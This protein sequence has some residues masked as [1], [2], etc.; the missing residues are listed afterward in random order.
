MLHLKNYSY[1]RGIQRIEIN[2]MKTTK[3]IIFTAIAVLA[4]LN[5]CQT[6]RRIS[7]EYYPVRQGTKQQIYVER[8]MRMLQS[9][10]KDSYAIA[11][12]QTVDKRIYIALSV[13]NNSDNI[14]TV[15]YNNIR[16]T[17][18]EGREIEYY[19]AREYIEHRAQELTDQKI[20]TD[21]LTAHINNSMN[22][23]RLYYAD[24][25]IKGFSYT[26]QMNFDKEMQG[27]QETLFYPQTLEK[28]EEVIGY[29]FLKIN[30]VPE[31]LNLTIEAGGDVHRLHYEF[32]PN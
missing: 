19:K 6:T 7:G 30:S 2:V 5:S 13:I 8:D 10:L 11:A 1:F 16:F 3:T 14:F 21:V 9:Q 20:Q 31:K 27:L 18:Q 25:Y 24:S 17:D 4:L 28:D 32:Q 26:E 29:I 15:D 22:S 23:N 12:V